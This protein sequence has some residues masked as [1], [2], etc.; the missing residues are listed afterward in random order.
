MQFVSTSVKGRRE[1]DFY[2][3]ISP[4]EAKGLGSKC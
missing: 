4:T 1:D 3:S 2:E